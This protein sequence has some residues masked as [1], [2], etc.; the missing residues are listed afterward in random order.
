MIAPIANPPCEPVRVVAMSRV[1]VVEHSAVTVTASPGA[2][3]PQMGTR[4]PRWRTML[5]SIRPWVRNAVE[6]GLAEPASAAAS[7]WSPKR[8][9]V[10]REKT[11]NAK[12]ENTMMTLILPSMK[13]G[14]FSREPLVG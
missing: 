5:S 12:E 3:Q 10:C 8:Q 4:T 9:A 13:S 7:A 6:S 11:W 1:S 2:A 14:P